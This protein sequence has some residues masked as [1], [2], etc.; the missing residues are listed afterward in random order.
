M[1]MMSKIMKHPQNQHIKVMCPV[2]VG[3]GASKWWFMT[4]ALT[5]RAKPTTLKELWTSPAL[6]FIIFD[7]TPKSV[8]AWQEMSS[9]VITKYCR[10]VRNDSEMSGREFKHCRTF[11]LGVVEMSGRQLP[12]FGTSDSKRMWLADWHF[13]RPRQRRGRGNRIGPVCVCVCVCVSVCNSAVSWLN[14]LT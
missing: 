8:W 7:M 4:D 10:H 6:E 12:I 13:Y 11:C 9:S 5:N 14:R 1:R 2:L 3:G